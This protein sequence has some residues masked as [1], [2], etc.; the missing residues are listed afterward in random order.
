MSSTTIRIANNRLACAYEAAGAQLTA[1]T[2]ADRAI[3]TPEQ[4]RAVI[5]QAGYFSAFPASRIRL[6]LARFSGTIPT[7]LTFENHLTHTTTLTNQLVWL[8]VVDDVP[9]TASG[10]NRPFTPKNLPTA[11]EPQNTSTSTP[12]N[13]LAMAA[14]IDGSEPAQ[15]VSGLS[16]GTQPPPVCSL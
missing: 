12:A 15:S 10:G 11:T 9:I 4:A 1:V 8:A 7:A 16:E 5:A 13:G 6:W 2:E 3:W 14:F